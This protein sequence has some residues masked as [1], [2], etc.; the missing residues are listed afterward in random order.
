MKEETCRSNMD[1]LLSA[2]GSLNISSFDPSN[3]R[4][5]FDRYKFQQAYTPDGDALKTT[6]FRNDAESTFFYN[7]QVVLKS[8]DEQE[9]NLMSAA[10]VSPKALEIYLLVREG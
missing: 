1:E 10:P 9:E 7:Y 6:L 8:S 2:F 5:L 3:D 4:E